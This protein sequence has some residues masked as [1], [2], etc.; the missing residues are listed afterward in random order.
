MAKSLD[1]KNKCIS[2][3]GYK[4][5]VPSPKSGIKDLVPPGVTV[6]GK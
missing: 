6:F 5:S 3:L 2:E 1:I 4:I